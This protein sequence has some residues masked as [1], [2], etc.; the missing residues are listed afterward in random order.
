MLKEKLFDEIAGKIS[1][2]IAASPAKDVE[3][4]VRAMMASAFT[5]MDLVTREEFEVQ[6]EVLVRS[7]EKLTELEARIAELEARLQ[8]NNPQDAL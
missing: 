7:R 3:K 2:V 8:T 1:D 5:K 4:N 6:Q